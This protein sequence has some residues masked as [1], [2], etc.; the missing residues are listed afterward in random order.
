LNSSTSSHG[1][2]A[3]REAALELATLAA[4]ETDLTVAL[5]V[6]EDD[7]LTALEDFGVISSHSSPFS[8]PLGDA[9]LM[10]VDDLADGTELATLAAIETD[11]TVAF[12]DSEAK[13]ELEDFVALEDLGDLGDSS[14]QSSSFLAFPLG[15]TVS[16]HLL[17]VEVEAALEV[18]TDALVVEVET[19]ALVDELKLATLASVETDFAMLL[20]WE[21]VDEALAEMDTEDSF[22]DLDEDLGDL[23]ELSIEDV[24]LG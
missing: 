10:V 7:D 22:D 24:A 2:D 21:A 6:E 18:E 8:E 11:L 19:D 17:Q 13:T 15:T 14:S 9:A 12:M 4:I 3:E 23:G 20:D 5:D 16:E 1:A